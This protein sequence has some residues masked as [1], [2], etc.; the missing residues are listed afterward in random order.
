MGI[1]D[2]KR[3]PEEKHDA[4]QAIICRCACHVP[5]S[6]VMHFI[7]CCVV[8][9]H[10]NQ[11]I[12][13]ESYKEHVSLCAEQAMKCSIPKDQV[14]LSLDDLTLCDRQVGVGVLMESSKLT[15]VPEIRSA[16]L[17]YYDLLVDLYEKHLLAEST[18]HRSGQETYGYED[19]ESIQHNLSYISDRWVT[20][21]RV[22]WLI[23]L[24]NPDYGSN[25]EVYQ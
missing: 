3:N 1:E 15:S 10:C 2:I 25:L 14:P 12:V 18:D 23:N 8:C 24:I 16:L 17:P 7:N 11:R 21:F 6:S 9:K 4:E 5:G 20:C 22:R 13:R 19:L